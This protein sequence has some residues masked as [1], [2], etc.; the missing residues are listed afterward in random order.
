MGCSETTQQYYHTHPAV[1]QSIR[2]GEIVVKD[3]AGPT[4]VAISPFVFLISKGS[5]TFKI[6]KMFSVQI[7]DLDTELLLFKYDF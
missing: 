7:R 5:G 1:K 6:N 2:R 3:I 4:A